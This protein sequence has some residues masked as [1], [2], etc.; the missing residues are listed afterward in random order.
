MS[1][2]SA[3]IT[4]TAWTPGRCSIN[5]WTPAQG[6]RGGNSACL[7]RR[8][9]RSASSRPTSPDNASPPSTRSLRIRRG[10]RTARRV[11]RVDGATTSSVPTSWSSRLKIDAGDEG[12]VHDMGGNIIPML[13]SQGT[14][15]R[16]R[17]LRQRGARHHRSGPGLL[18]RRRKPGR[19]P[20]R[21]HGSGQRA[22]SSTSTKQVADPDLLP[23]LPP[24]K[25]A[26][27]ATP[28]S[29]WWGRFDHLRRPCATVRAVVR[30]AG[31]RRRL[32]SRAR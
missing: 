27:A 8:R 1:R 10:F 31:G 21:P 32:L 15:P 3:P 18:A 28:T 25:F 13:T 30:R 4:S 29:R 12:S 23:P 20:R 16:V 24:A 2:S 7:P 11:L 14:G 5:T 17:L 22:R 6:H 26:W 9:P 19:L